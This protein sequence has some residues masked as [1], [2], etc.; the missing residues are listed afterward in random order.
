[1]FRL[2][3]VSRLTKKEELGLLKP[4]RILSASSQVRYSISTAKGTYGS[5]NTFAHT[6]GR[7]CF[8]AA[9]NFELSVLGVS[10][11]LVVIIRIADDLFARGLSIGFGD[12]S[13]NRDISTFSESGLV[14]WAGIVTSVQAALFRISH[15]RNLARWLTEARADADQIC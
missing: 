7:L 6:C 5:Q 1:M 13:P 10:N 12:L 15:T 14:P 8:L 3:W 11:G 2:L 4:I 9:L